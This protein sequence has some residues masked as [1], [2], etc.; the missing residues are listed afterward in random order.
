MNPGLGLEREREREDNNKI[1][2]VRLKSSNN[3]F[4]Q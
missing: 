2:D 3:N 4:H 1:H